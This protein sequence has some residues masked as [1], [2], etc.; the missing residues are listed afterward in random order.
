MEIATP[1]PLPADF[2]CVPSP[3]AIASVLADD[4]IV[5]MPPL[6]I[7]RPS[8]IFAVDF[9]IATLTAIAPATSIGV[10]LEE[11]PSPLVEAFG[12]EVWP[13]LEP[14]FSVDVAFRNDNWSSVFWFAFL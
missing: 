12:D 8:A 5:T 14:P 9:V 3:V 13:L 4:L 1:T 11:L 7:V 2:V 6:V 10:P